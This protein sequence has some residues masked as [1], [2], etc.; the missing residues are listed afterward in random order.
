MTPVELRARLDDLS[1]RLFAASCELEE[2]LPDLTL[3]ADR[4][5]AQS[6]VTDLH[7]ATENCTVIG[8]HQVGEALD[9][10]MGFGGPPA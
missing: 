6:I 2:L 1:R 8:L 4:R 10:Q 5:A 7:W 9:D 3:P